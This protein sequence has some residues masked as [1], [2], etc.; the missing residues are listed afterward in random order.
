[1]NDVIYIICICFLLSICCFLAYKLYQFSLI[2]LNVEEAVEESLELLASKHSRMSEILQKPV[3]FDSM[4]VRQVI[5]DIKDCHTAIMLIGNK[6]TN[7]VG[8]E[9]EIKKESSEEES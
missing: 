8:I 4:E 7:D 2:I 6:L 5:S 3:F 9:S 1:M